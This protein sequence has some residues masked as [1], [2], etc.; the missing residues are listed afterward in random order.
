VSVLNT[1]SLRFRQIS[2]NIRSP[3]KRLYIYIYPAVD[4]KPKKRSLATD[5]KK[6][7]RGFYSINET[8]F[9]FVARF[10]WLTRAYSELIKFRQTLYVRSSASPK[11]FKNF[12][13]PSLP[14]LYVQYRVLLL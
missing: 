7:S 13:R 14:K 2:E 5:C 9:C 3:I 12:V 6:I 10:G 8:G 4:S 11:L 1:A